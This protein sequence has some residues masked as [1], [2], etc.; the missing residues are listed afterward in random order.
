MSDKFRT[1]FPIAITFSS[2]E[3]PTSK[4]LNAISTQAK[5]GLALIERAIGDLWNQSGD[6]ITSAYPNQIV[7]IAR[8]MGESVLLNSSMQ[9]PDFGTVSEIKIQQNITRGS[10]EIKLKYYP[11]NDSDLADTLNDLEGDDGS[12]NDAKLTAS[13]VVDERQWYLNGDTLTIHLGSPIHATN[14]NDYIEY[15]VAVEDIPKDSY[16]E[17]LYNVI[18]HP[19]Q[20]QWNGI[21]IVPTGT[22]GKYLL[23]LPFRRPLDVMPVMAPEASGSALNEPTATTKYYYGP[24]EGYTPIAGLTDEPYY[25]YSLPRIIKDMFIAPVAGTIIPS[26]TLYLWNNSTQTIVEGVTFKIPETAITV[27][28]QVPFVIQV[29]G[30]LLDG[31]FSGLTSTFTTLADDAPVSYRSEYSIIAAGQSLAGAINK[32]KEDIYFNNVPSAR[33]PLAHNKLTGLQP[34]RSTRHSI[35]FPNS[36][37]PNDD[38][39]HL[40]SRLGSSSSSAQHRDRYNNAMLGDLLMG[41]TDSTDNYQNLNGSYRRIY[42]GKVNSLAPSLSG[43]K[44]TLAALQFPS[45]D[46]AGITVNGGLNIGGAWMRLGDQYLIN[47]DTKNIA[48]FDDGGDRIGTLWPQRILFNGHVDT[49]ETFNGTANSTRYIDI[50]AIT[51][52]LIKFKGGALDISAVTADTNVLTIG[53]NNANTHLRLINKKIEFGNAAVSI[54]FNSGINTFEFTGNISATSFK[55]SSSMGGKI[56][57]PLDL[58]MGGGGA[59]LGDITAPSA[60][61]F[62][63]GF[64]RKAAPPTYKYNSMGWSISVGG[65]EEPNLYYFKVPKLPDDAVI[66]SVVF[67]GNYTGTGASTSY[68]RCSFI[69]CDSN[70]PVSSPSPLRPTFG[71]SG[72]EYANTAAIGS[73][74]NNKSLTATWS[75][76]LDIGSNRDL[77]LI[78]GVVGPNTE[79]N[80]HIYDLHSIKVNFNYTNAGF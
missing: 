77:Y 28:G 23:V 75:P 40:L 72:D 54:A 50:D 31:L 24:A 20:V 1:S 12:Y 39:P 73:T 55:L 66:Y 56:F 48:F 43:T 70:N 2:G 80:D 49:I 10:S 42:F 37:I 8:N 30:S 32:L 53:A 52:N 33:A 16:S 34:V 26:G 15:N 62:G 4:K 67:K 41:S 60:A 76:A 38:H 18:P 63:S 44:D 21:K 64:W 47:T 13:E 22:S 5:N 71:V 27:L 45:G 9:A 11:V 51:S 59:S 46:G 19:G 3:Q 29:E 79:S 74:A 25:R 65:N 14:G 69:T 7:N 57:V 78:V 35:N 36:Y 61:G 17:G 68:L 58:Q 6:S